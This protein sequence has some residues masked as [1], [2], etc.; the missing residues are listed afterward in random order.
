LKVL[1]LAG[2][3]G[4]TPLH[5]AAEDGDIESLKTLLSDGVRLDE[6]NGMKVI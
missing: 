4:W 1:K 2:A 3:D 5:A 6:I